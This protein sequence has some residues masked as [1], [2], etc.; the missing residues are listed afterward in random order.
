MRAAVVMVGV[1][2]LSVVLAVSLLPVSASANPRGAEPC[3][4]AD[5]DVVGDPDGAEY[6]GSGGLL[7]P[8]DSFTGTAQDRSDA[9][10]CTGCQWALLPMCRTGQGGGVACGGAAT[11][12]PPGEFRRIV[13][14]LRPGDTE[15]REVGLVCL[16][17]GAPT[18]VDDVAQRL[19]DVV[20]E[21]VPDLNP[22]FQP[23]G[24]TLVGLP[25]VFDAGQPRTLGG[26]RFTLVGFDIV[27]H[28]RATWM[29]TFGDGGS[30]V[31]DAPGGAWPNTDVSHTY[32]RSGEYAVGVVTEWE[33]WFTVDGMGPWPVGGEPVTQASGPLA[34]RV[35]EARAQLVTG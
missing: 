22:S 27:L 6:V 10:T 16:V 25:A 19:S 2:V 29:W 34:L 13:M 26:R 12:C 17:G 33:A 15:W 1:S 30:L 28:G 11:S 35:L 14:L 20:V 5:C 7:L 23:R 32:S 8:A 31:T 18:T 9:A 24:G 21:Q 3:E 4:G